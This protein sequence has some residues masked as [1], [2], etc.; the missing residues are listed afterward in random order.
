[1]SY[2]ISQ[3]DLQRDQACLLDLWQ[4][5][6]PEASRSRYGWLYETGRAT[7]WLLNCREESA[8]GSTGLMA[9]TFNAFGEV[10]E[11]G[12]AIDLN[13]DKAHRTMGPALGLQRAV[14]A[15]VKRRQFGLVY[16]FPSAQSESV[17]RRAGYKVLGGVERWYKPLRCDEVFKD[18]LRHRLAGKVASTVVGSALRVSF[19]EKLRRRPTDLDV[20]VTDHFDARFDLLWQ[21]AAGRFPIVGERTSDYLNWRFRRCPNARYRVFC[22]TGARRELLAYV[23]Y[24]RHEDT[25]HVNDLFF[26]EVDN[27]NYLLAEFLRLMR[28]QGAKAVV[29]VYQGSETVSQTLRRFGFWKRPSEWR[30]MLYVDREWFGPHA[31]AVFDPENWHLTRADVDT[32]F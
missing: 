22:L 23:V 16:A 31:D 30:T 17:L 8:V 5:N 4:R 3:P 12:Q 11:A 1:M 18:R 10:L 27:L 29:T 6:L 19:P 9:R 14:T 2:T 7:G 13:V 25:V 20:H 21:A 15:T 26:A 24:A 28:R 32:D